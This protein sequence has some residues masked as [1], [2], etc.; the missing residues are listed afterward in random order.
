MS[1]Q[2]MN[3]SVSRRDD[4][5][6]VTL[7]EKRLDSS[8]TPSFKAELLRIIQSG[9]KKLLINMKEVKSIDSSGL[10]TL[11]F[12]LRQLE[13][14]NGE[15]AVCCVRGKVL[16]L[17]QIAKLDRVIPIYKTEKEGLE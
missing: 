15:I 17:F 4:V 7:H 16:A 1:E 6:V 2:L 5:W 9:A 3:Y 8:I 10:G 11:T 14:V 13:E 12:G